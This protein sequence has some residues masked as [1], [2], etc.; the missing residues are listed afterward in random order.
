VPGSYVLTF[1]SGKRAVIDDE[2]H[3]DRRLGNLLER[4]CLW[5]LRCTDRISDVDVSDTGD[6]Y[7]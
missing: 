2:V 3:R 6:C 5:I 4:N 1:L 7:D